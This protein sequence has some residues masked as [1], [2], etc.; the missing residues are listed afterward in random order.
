MD[1]SSRTRR[2]DSP[3]GPYLWII[4]VV[5][6]VECHGLEQE[7]LVDEA[8]T[9]IAGTVGAE[10]DGIRPVHPEAA[11]MHQRSEAVQWS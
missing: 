8:V 11:V 7:P 6:L 4:A 2:G 5:Y 10:L 9:E 3:L 1:L